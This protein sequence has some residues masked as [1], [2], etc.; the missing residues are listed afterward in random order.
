MRL[1]YP[2]VL[3]VAVTCAACGGG[4]D[5]PSTSTSGLATSA[6]SQTCAAVGAILS[7]GPDPD[8]DPIGYAE[9][10]VRPLRGVETS[11]TALADAVAALADAY[12]RQFQD[13]DGPPERAAVASAEQRMNVLCPGAA[14]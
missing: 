11:D 2:A 10:Q 13:G 7:D 8:A 9:A 4:G 5:S 3:A 1:I 12:Q 6:V 14:P